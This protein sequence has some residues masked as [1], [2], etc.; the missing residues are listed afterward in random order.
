MGSSGRGRQRVG[1]VDRNHLQRRED[2]LLQELEQRLAAHLLDD[3]PCN[4]V[5][6]V[7]VLVAGAWLVVERLVAPALD[8]RLG[9]DGLQPVRDCVVLRTAILVPRR[10]RQELADGDFIGAREVGQVLR[11]LVVE[12]QLAFLL[13][14]Q[15]AR[16][17]ELLRD[18]TDLVAHR[19]V[20]E[21]LRLEPCKPVGLRIDR[22]AVAHDGDRGAGH[23]GQ[24]QDLACCGIDARSGRS[25]QSIRCCGVGGGGEC[26][27]RTQSSACGHNG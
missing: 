8:V 22:A 16:D 21:L 26:R 7:A 10:M 25:R 15:E 1:V 27:T 5:A 23:T 12:R 2:P 3:A 9:G 4:R 14:Q 24:L 6:R 17:E 19:G 20:R 11:H 18:R 13:Q